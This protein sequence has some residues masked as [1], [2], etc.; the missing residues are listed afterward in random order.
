[1]GIW[2]PICC[3]I[4]LGFD[5]CVANMFFIPV[6]MWHGAD[7]SLFDF[8][9]KAMVPVTLG[10]WMGAITFVGAFYTYVHYGAVKRFLKNKKM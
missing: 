6:G 5:H 10:N 8:M 3:Y 9:V 1:M 7:I 4:T 2:W